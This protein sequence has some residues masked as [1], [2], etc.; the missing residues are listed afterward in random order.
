MRED[1]IRLKIVDHPGDHFSGLKII[2]QPAI[3]GSWPKGFAGTQQ[4]RCGFKLLLSNLGQ[5][6]A[7][8]GG[9]K[10]T[11]IRHRNHPD[12][13]AGLG[14]KFQSPTAVFIPIIVMRPKHQNIH[15]SS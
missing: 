5:F 4:G 2:L 11:S 3:R 6:G 7:G 15:A 9:A 14:I 12:G 13:M 1:D 10:I 8:S